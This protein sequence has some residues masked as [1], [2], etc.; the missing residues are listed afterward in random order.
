MPEELPAWPMARGTRST[1]AGGYLS[2][3]SLKPHAHGH[4]KKSSSS[5][6]LPQVLTRVSVGLHGSFH[7]VRVSNEQLCVKRVTR[8][9][10]N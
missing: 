4:F 9:V 8:R 3:Y 1:R 2:V 6:S 7:G 5:P 10:P